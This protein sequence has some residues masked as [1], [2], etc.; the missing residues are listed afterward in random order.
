MKKQWMVVMMA[1]CCALVSGCARSGRDE[2]V[3]VSYAVDS[4]PILPELQWHE[5]YTITSGQVVFTRSGKIEQT[6]ANAG[7]WTLDV[8]PQ[9]IDSLFKQLAALDTSSMQRVEPEDA[10][11]GGITA[12]YVITYASGKTFSLLLDPGVSYTHGE[13]L[14][15][16]IL[17][18]I[19]GLSIPVDAASRQQLVSP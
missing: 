10:P 5:Q 9:Q 2:I 17:Q 12:S 1:L 7:S 16:P 11:D 6:L 8:K 14:A 13:T 15:D 4:G 3:Q 19:Q 18:F